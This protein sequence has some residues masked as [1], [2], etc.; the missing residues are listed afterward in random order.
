M[1]NDRS[2]I[3]VRDRR[4]DTLTS[5]SCQCPEPPTEP[6]ALFPRNDIAAAIRQHAPKPAAS[7][8]SIKHRWRQYMNGSADASAPP[9]TS[10]NGY[11]NRDPPGSVHAARDKRAGSD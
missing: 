9:P 1:E 4:D 2:P 5:W 7:N 8:P 11:A 6:Y 3:A 10:F